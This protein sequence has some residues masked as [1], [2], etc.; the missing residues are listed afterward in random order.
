VSFF[1]SGKHL[2]GIG[3]ETVD[4]PLAQLSKHFSCIHHQKQRILQLGILCVE[5]ANEK[6]I[7]NPLPPQRL[8][9]L[10]RD[11]YSLIG[12]KQGAREVEKLFP[13]GYKTQTSPKE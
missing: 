7:N 4:C 5:Y 1:Q 11:N 10:E 3:R 8:V 12:P 6:K 9:F 13:W 2:L